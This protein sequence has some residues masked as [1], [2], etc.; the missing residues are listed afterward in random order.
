MSFGT[1]SPQPTTSSNAFGSNAVTQNA[2]RSPWGPSEPYLNMAGGEA[3]RLLQQ[4]VR[5]YGGQ[6]VADISPWETQGLS[7]MQALA[8]Q[9][10]QGSANLGN[11]RAYLN[12]IIQSHG[13]TPGIQEAINNI[14]GV[15]GNLGSVAGNIGGVAGNLG[16]V[17]AQY[18]D[19]YH[20]Q[21]GQNNPYL[22]AILDSQNQRIGDRV[23]ASMSGAGR[24]GSGQHT[25]VMTRGL[26]EAEAPVLAQDYEAR[27]ARELQATQ[28]QA[29]AYGAQAGAYGTQA[30]VYGTQGGMYGT[31]A[32]IYGRGLAQAGQAAQLTPT[33]D[34]ARYMP[35]QIMSQVGQVYTDQAQRQLDA[36]RQQ[37]NEQ[38]YAPYQNLSQFANIVYPSAGFGGT[39]SGTFTGTN[40]NQNQAFGFPAP[41]GQRALGGAIAGGALGSRFGGPLGAGLG[42]LGGGA[43]GFL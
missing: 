16:N 21:Q 38:T 6:M 9:E 11:A 31:Q 12:D 43:L 5:P 23:N 15:A 2:V 18:G 40:T 27:Q 24:Y 29:G 1:P 35:G 7:A 8:Y 20:Q 37:F 25:D 42:A 10:P 30:G 19:I 26:A 13:I 41:A 36:A 33:L 34:A 28:G 17:A 4:E 39:T 22:Q 14:G 32:D 3:S